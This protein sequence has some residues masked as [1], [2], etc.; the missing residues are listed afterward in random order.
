MHLCESHWEEWRHATWQ[1][2]LDNVKQPIM[3]DWIRKA[4]AREAVLAKL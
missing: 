3:E 2:Y 1:A 4:G